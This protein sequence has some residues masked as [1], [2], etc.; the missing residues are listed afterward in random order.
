M[1]IGLKFSNVKIL[2][3]ILACLGLLAAASGGAIWYAASEMK[4]LDNTYTA[5]LEKDVEVMKS[6]LELQNRVSNFGRLSWR[7]IAETKME[8]MKKTAVEIDTNW[9]A[10]LPLVAEIKKLSSEYGARAEQTYALYD[11]LHREEY[12]EIEKV[13]MKNENEEATQ[14]AQAMSARNVVIRNQ[15]NSLVKDVEKRVQKMSDEATVQTHRAITVTVVSVLSL[16]H[17]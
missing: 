11:K 15:L 10:M 6:V 14:R 13:T 16:I 7:I 8:D 5:I 2:Y 3:K 9:K 12:L 4:S 1:K 17:I